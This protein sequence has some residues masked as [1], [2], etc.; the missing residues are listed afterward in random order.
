MN[1]I[2]IG[3]DIGSTT[4]KAVV[5]DASNH[6]IYHAYERH[7]YQVQQRLVAI[8]SDL[9][10]RF[11]DESV[12]L[13]LTGMGAIDLSDALALPF[14]QEV[15]AEGLA[16]QQ[17]H[18]AVDVAIEIG[19]EDAKMTY[20]D[21]G[22]EPDQ[23]MNRM[24]AGGT[25]A[26]LDHLAAF[27]GTDM[28]GL[29]E[30]ATQ[31]KVVYPIA[32]RCGVYAKTDM[33]A[34]LN[35][36][37][38]KAD[39]ALSAFHAV[40]RQVVS[41]LAKGRAIA[42]KVAFL[43]GPLT[44]LPVLRSCFMDLL[45]RE[46]AEV[47]PV[48]RG[49]LYGALGAA[50]WGRG[51]V[52]IFLRDLVSRLQQVGQ[53]KGKTPLRGPLFRDEKEYEDFRS[54]YEK[55][56]V[57]CR[58]ST[59]WPS[60]VWLGIDAGST[61][62]KLVLVDEKGQIVYQEYRKNAADL[63][64]TARDMV[65]A[66]YERMP[67]GV[68]IV[69]A[70][71]TG[72]GEAFL[73]QAFQLDFGEV[74]TVAHIRGARFFC[75]EVTDVLDIGGQDMKY[76]RLQDGVIRDIVLNGSC[77]SGC[78]VF[79]ETFAGTLGLRMDEFVQ[80]ALTAR[81]WLDLG[82]HCTVLLHSQVHQLQNEKVEIGDLIAGLCMSVIKNALY[83]VIHLRD[84]SD[85]GSH[86]VV[87]GGTFC[88]DAVLRAFEKLMGHRVIR[89]D[90][91]GVMGAYGMA[92]LAKERFPSSHRSSI[93]S[94]KEI[95]ALQVEERKQ[96]CPSCGNHCLLQQKL[97]SNGAMF[98]TG[99][100]CS[101]GEAL[102]L[103]GK[104][105]KSQTHNLYEWEKQHL[106]RRTTVKRPL[107]GTVGM[108]QVLDMWSDF[109]YWQAF[110]ASLGYST[111]LS[112]Y[113]EEMMGKSAS[114]VPHGIYC[115]P[116][117]LAHGHVMDLLE[118]KHISFVWM[119]VSHRG[120]E[121][122]ELDVLPHGTY[123]DTINQHMKA[124]S[125]QSGISIL[126]PAVQ[127]G[128]EKEIQSFMAAQFPEISKEE[129]AWA[130]RCGKEAMERYKNELQKETKR[131]LEVIHREK[132]NALVL[133]GRNYH[134]DPEINKGLP[135][136]IAKLGI[137]VLTAE[138]LYSLSSN[139]KEEP[140]F[141]D[142][143]LYALEVAKRD[144][145][146]HLV[147]LQSTSCGYDGI[148]MQEI[149]Q[150]LASVGKIYTL[151]NLDQGISTGMLQIRIRSLM[152]EIQERQNHPEW[153]EPLAV[154]AV[155][156]VPK[157]FYLAPLGKWYDRLLQVAWKPLGYEVQLA[158]KEWMTI[159]DLPQEADQDDWGGETEQGDKNKKA[160]LFLSGLWDA[161]KAEYFWDRHQS[162]L[163][164]LFM[165]LGRQ[166]SD[167]PP[168]TALFH[169]T[170]MALF[171]GDLL[172]R[173][174][175]ASREEMGKEET[176]KLLHQAEIICIGALQKSSFAAYEEAVQQCVQL[177]SS[178]KKKRRGT[179]GLLGNPKAAMELAE[180]I[181]D[182]SEEP[183]AIKM[184]GWGETILHE[185]TELYFL[186]GFQGNP[187]AAQ[188]CMASRKC[189]HTCLEIMVAKVNSTSSLDPLETPEEKKDRLNRW[190]QAP[191]RTLREP[192]ADLLRRKAGK[193][194]STEGT[195]KQEAAEID[196]L[197]QLHPS[198]EVLSLGN[199]E[200]GSL[201]TI[202]RLELFLKV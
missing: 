190:R 79:L 105:K 125:W 138:G 183:L 157:E 86:I 122:P 49:E 62:I 77:A 148:T 83:R 91:S 25:G 142:Q 96:R 43:G 85:L 161:R 66:M 94:A 201:Q 37:A 40:A 47:V 106:F 54:Y 97:F 19:G 121:E 133:L 72:Y 11:S 111:V 24:C 67:A 58:E 9:A 82:Y 5:L 101:H 162:G 131:V 110:W 114:T 120:M 2:S 65:L 44:F 55:F 103:R 33:Q 124:W 159:N 7:G 180:V 132:R 179:L 107:R 89:P 139:K 145:Y 153:V 36:G 200:I 93:L 100:K 73:K 64:A 126:H 6:L 178:I 175:L 202:N 140:T 108:P 185:L 197:H 98:V 130:L 113:R 61:T 186:E 199:A 81:H 75:P 115:Y 68:R 137:P 163:T 169:Q 27:L 171:L 196:I 99:N 30:L 188:V 116:C 168:S 136:Q 23:R 26:F 78:G 17:L 29:N 45:D 42:G 195:G 3:I 164:A 193:I 60:E 176:E 8:L 123:G 74:E 173:G 141:R 71:V 158:E 174:Y 39:L 177:F 102:L 166:Q 95:V 152:A 172:L 143:A 109:P 32:S 135:M 182:R 41:D 84:I 48:E 192:M 57:P 127:P 112:S 134:I 187:E 20:F 144:P 51:K 88:N 52:S 34:L 14:V 129:V 16:L 151:L 21:K 181:Y 119:P 80:K 59:D 38:G 160:V 194:I 117:K 155:K 56:H 184:Q 156:E 13:A 198:V 46:N 76:I 63:L 92:L 147:Q 118:R 35:Q 87:E 90:A 18:G 69:G 146:L 189:A 22:K 128:Q 150:G 31:G 10:R 28:A 53:A 15:K 191:A 4:I 170:W 165:G 1:H 50:L 12:C 154:K 70:G 149:R 104:G 167:E